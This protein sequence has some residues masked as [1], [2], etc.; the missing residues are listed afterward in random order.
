LQKDDF[1]NI[2]IPLPDNSIQTQIVEACRLINQE[3]E[4]AEK[5]IM[6]EK[7]KIEQL[8]IDFSNQGYP[9]KQVS[10]LADV[11]PS[12]TELQNIDENT[13]VSFV[14][15]AS[16]SEKG[17][18]SYKE[19]RLLKDVKAGSYRYFKNNDIIIAKITPC[20]ENGKCAIANDLTNGIGFGSSE[21]HVFRV[22]EASVSSNFLFAFLNR[23]TVRKEA[24][25]NMTGSSGHRRV[26]D[27]F[28]KDMQIP[29]PT[30][31][32]KQQKLIEE[33][34]KSCQ[35]IDVAQNVMNGVAERKEDILRSY[36]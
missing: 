16:V 10:A 21:F 22:N 9:L 29:V 11:N 30:D 8:L 6:L 12:K 25:R 13:L 5:T 18:I 3:F 26:P 19:D 28:Y 14:E 15:M 32:R 7:A 31:K 1:K 2:K 17:Y 4:T 34:E 23:E 27:T 33:I 24:E 35:K 20:M 36:L